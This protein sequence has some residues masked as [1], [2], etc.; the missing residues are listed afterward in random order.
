M[1][2]TSPSPLPR[3]ETP[4]EAAPA[5]A[6]RPRRRK[7]A[8][9]A[10]AARQP[11]RAQAEPSET[12][13]EIGAPGD[14][15]PDEL[16][17]MLLQDIVYDRLRQTRT[18]SAE[19]AR[20]APAE[21]PSA[22]AAQAVPQDFVYD[23]EHPV[24]PVPFSVQLGE[25]R[26]NGVGLS[27]TAAYVA[28]P[29]P[30]DLRPQGHREVV[31][32]LF[33]FNGFSLAL[34]AEVVVS[35][36]RRPGEMTLQFMDPL[37]PHL[38][39]LRHIINSY[40]GGDLVSLGGLLSYAGPTKPKAAKAAEADSLKLRIRSLGMA[41]LSL[42]L[43]VA[44]AALM[45]N[46]ATQT[47]EVRPVF[48]ARE[49]HDMRATT[50]GQVSYL[51]P[52]AKAGEV[53]FSINSNTG[54][55]LNFQ[56]PCDCEVA[57]TEGI[58]EGATVLPI[59]LIL[60][61]FDSNPGVRV[62]TLISIEGLARVMDGDRAHLDIDDGRS[63]PVRVEV[64]SATNAAAG[65]GDLFVPVDLVPT[66]GELGQDDIGKVARLRLSTPWLPDLP[67]SSGEDS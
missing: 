45:L 65:R 39:Q 16:E 48:I 34:P 66:G 5:D 58:F 60:T 54:D 1:S 31:R 29:D 41:A 12:V 43:I 51:N 20:P 44:A 8:A 47:H 28:T 52:Q 11:S 24:L 49:G 35:G 19:A 2:D 57:V 33:E 13:P 14:P 40:I 55:A 61:F 18:P 37:G 10:S 50:A 36:A 7:P 26:L 27:V 38:P 30:L 64:T 46:R 67:F 4:R 22:A 15:R 23:S 63:I 59:D 3:P 32:L 9:A 42:A 56:L 62:Q 21:P 53:V 17:R 25:S 6:A